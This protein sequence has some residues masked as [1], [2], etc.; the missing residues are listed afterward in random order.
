MFLQ[1]GIVQGE[2]HQ[3]ILTHAPIPFAAAAGA[4]HPAGID[5]QPDEIAPPR[6]RSVAFAALRPSDSLAAGCLRFAPAPLFPMIEPYPPSYPCIE[7]PHGGIRVADSDVV[8][9]ARGIAPQFV[10]DELDVLPTVAFGDLIR[11]AHPPGSL[12][13]VYLRCASFPSRAV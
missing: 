7:F 3:T 1:V 2:A 11:S 12:S 9:P 5:S 6:P 8:H 10:D 4:V 13:A